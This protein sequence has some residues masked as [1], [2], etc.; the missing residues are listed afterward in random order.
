MTN[1]LTGGDLSFVRRR[2]LAAAGL[3]FAG[4]FLAIVLGWVGVSG[5]R[6]L[7]DQLSYI[8]SGGVLGLFLLG[9]G[10]AI[11]L[12]DFL[13][14]LESSVNRLEGR[15]DELATGGDSNY[16]EWSD[17]VRHSLAAHGDRAPLPDGVF[18]AVPGAKRYH[19]VNCAMVEGKDSVE[20]VGERSIDERGLIPCK[21]CGAHVAA[22]ATATDNLAVPV[23]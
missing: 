22:A 7:A 8:A 6:D 18:L 12:T 15:L 4:G 14:E 13:M 1:Y 16:D 11:L 3:C 9:L 2:R 21:V 20:E 5:T 10:A 23:T 19:R 17:P